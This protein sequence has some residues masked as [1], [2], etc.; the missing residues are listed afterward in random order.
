MKYK[1]KQMKNLIVLTGGIILVSGFLSL[2]LSNTNLQIHSNITNNALAYN[3]KTTHPDLTRE[4]ITFYE[5]S[6]GKKFTE[7]QKHWIVQGSIDEDF[8]PRWLNH[9]YDPIF[10]RG[11]STEIPGINGYL[12]KN[13][14]QFSSYQ[15]INVGNILNLW[16]GNGPV[17]SGSEYGDF[18]YEAAIKNYSQNKEKEAYLALG[19]LLHLIEDMTVPEHTRNDPHPGGNDVSFYENWTMS[20]S[21]GLTQD[22][23]KRLFNQD[24][25]P[26]IY[27]SLETYFNN[28]AAYTNNGFFSPDTIKS[29]IYQKPKI[30]YE[31]GV[32]AYGKDENGEL[33]DLAQVI[34][35][36]NVKTYY[37][38]RPQILQEY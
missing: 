18:S 13:W 10:E 31:D 17:I 35:D 20:N 33:F 8:A 9:F 25:K 23:G 27:G 6:T 1:P 14:A 38:N 4:I 7:E 5:L 36:K 22:L 26:V 28:L 16:T 24:S 37:L 2:A 34:N 29:E 21:S 15:T 19:H 11:L 12:A 30:V 3:D 32:F